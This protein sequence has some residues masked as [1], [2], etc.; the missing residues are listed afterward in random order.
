MTVCR[1]NTVERCLVVLGQKASLGDME[2]CPAPAMHIQ[3]IQLGAEHGEMALLGH[4]GAVSWA[5]GITENMVGE[6]AAPHMVFGS[7]WL[8]CCS[9]KLFSLTQELQT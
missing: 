5:P 4:P 3:C 6:E 7:V 9:L 2:V 1:G 8:W